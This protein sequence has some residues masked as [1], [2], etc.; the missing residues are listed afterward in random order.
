MSDVLGRVAITAA[1]D[2]E[3]L[4]GYIAERTRNALLAEFTRLTRL[5]R[6]FDG[7]AI[8]VRSGERLPWER[9]SR[10][11]TSRNSIA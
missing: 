8:T 3:D 7:R 6:R 5:F 9:P 1:A 4:V 11:S 2:L 10:E